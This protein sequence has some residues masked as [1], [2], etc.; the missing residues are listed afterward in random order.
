[1]CHSLWKGIEKHSN[2]WLGWHQRNTRTYSAICSSIVFII[3]SF[4]WDWLLS[5]LP[6]CSRLN[7]SVSV[8]SSTVRS[9]EKTV[10]NE[11][12][13]SDKQANLMALWGFWLKICSRWKVSHRRET[14][15]MS[16]CKCT[17]VSE[18]SA[19]AFVSPFN[20]WNTPNSPLQMCLTHN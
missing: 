15:I 1:M 13:A 9:S 2:E 8:F 5:P 11:C 6:L 18:T 4:G 14:R 16:K 19:I 17:S 10:S 20:L 7:S 3:F 12:M